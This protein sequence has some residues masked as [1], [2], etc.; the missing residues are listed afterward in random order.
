MKT[1]VFRGAMLAAAPAALM[2]ASAAHAGAFY[3]QEQSVRA[4]G[5][6]FSGEVADTGAASLWWNPAAIGGMTG[7]DSAFGISAILPK[8]K[9]TNNNTLIKRP[10]NAAP[11]AV[12]GDQVS[13]DPINNG[14]L[15]SGSIA[16][17]ITP[18]VALGLAISSPYSFT[19]NYDSTSWVRYTA[20]K[21]MLRT[22]DIQ[23]SIAFAPNEHISLGVA[24]NAEHSKASLSNFLPN[25][26][27]L[28]PDGHQTLKGNGW[29]FGWTA[30]AQFRTDRITIGGSYKSS[31]K[32][33]LDGDVITAGLLG[34]LATQNGTISTKATFRTPWQA[35]FGA[36]FKATDK[37][38][39]NGQIVRFGWNK[40]DT[41]R[42]GAPIN[43]ALP[44]N[45]KNTWSF[46]GGLDYAVNE[47]WTL[48]SG[49][50]YDQTPT[51]DGNR[52]ARVPDGDRWNFAAGTS[53]NLTPGFTIDAAANY[54]TVKNASIDRTT[55]AYA[56]TAVQ[57]PILVN[58]E[59][60]K[61]SV[62]VF[63]LGGR[64]RF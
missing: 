5:R 7:G 29:D 24:L 52:D 45:Y 61:A 56:G 42:L 62:L 55:A 1:I 36:R 21:T 31:V 64:L 57:T 34:P 44:E 33:V 19:T 48:R 46:A 51:R 2:A 3:L 28:Q 15:P 20:D 4:A 23:P 22:F 38:T 35:T 6:A 43:A 16:Y 13:K 25:L 58:G 10:T 27:A 63:A 59:L 9:V 18:K 49:I 60:R 41:I 12:G 26:S 32:H 50:Q 11:V 39:L 54:L 17:G 53:Y 30:G 14:Y 37:L 47:K 40:F 8:G